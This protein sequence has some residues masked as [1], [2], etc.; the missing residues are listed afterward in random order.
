M[1]VLMPLGSLTVIVLAVILFG[2][3][4]A[5]ESAAVGAADA[6]ILAFHRKRRFRRCAGCFEFVNRIATPRCSEPAA[7]AGLK[8]CQSRR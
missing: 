6:F 4:T 8:N 7:C 1:N 3:T 2:I 5:T